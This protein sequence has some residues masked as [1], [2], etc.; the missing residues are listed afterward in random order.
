MAYFGPLCGLKT[1]YH[2]PLFTP[3]GPHSLQIVEILG[4]ECV[5]GKQNFAQESHFVYMCD[6]SS[7][8]Q[9]TRTTLTSALHGR[10]DG[11]WSVLSQPVAASPVSRLCCTWL[12]EA[13]SGKRHRTWRRFTRCHVA[14]LGCCRGKAEGMGW[15]RR[16]D[17]NPRPA[18]Y[19][20]AA[21]PLSYCG[22]FADNARQAPAPAG[23]RLY[24]LSLPVNSNRVNDRRPSRH[25]LRT[26]CLAP[27]LAY[28]PLT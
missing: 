8:P 24:R 20:C 4:P 15:C 10:S 14:G 9:S 13:E 16:R 11:R 3:H 28:W 22:L 1:W 2:C 7:W 17:L 18:H 12:A 27:P 21:L 25:W 19:E 5:P 23:P 6:R 26:D